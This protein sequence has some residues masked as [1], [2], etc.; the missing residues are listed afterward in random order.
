[1][2]VCVTFG[3]D[4]CVNSSFCAACREADQ[5]EA[6][7]ERPRHIDVSIWNRRPARNAR[8]YDSMSLSNFGTCSTA[9]VRHRKPRSKRSCIPRAR[10]TKALH[11]PANLEPSSRCDDAALAKIDARIAKLKRSR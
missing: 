9:N 11:E 10:G 2:S 7:G 1:M 4:P 8:D 6:R 5:R 3:A